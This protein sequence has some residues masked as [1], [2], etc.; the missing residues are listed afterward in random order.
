[1]FVQL[2]CIVLNSESR[3]PPCRDRGF[4]YIHTPIITTSDCEGA[5]E[6]FQVTTIA[7]EAG[8]PGADMPRNKDNTVD[9]K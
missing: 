3:P 1:M 4:L 5:G 7:P 2:C 9:Y 8:K 6:M